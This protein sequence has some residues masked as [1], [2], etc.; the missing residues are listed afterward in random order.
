MKGPLPILGWTLLSLALMLSFFFDFANVSEG[1]AIDLRNRITGVRLLAHGIDPF[2]YK[3]HSGEPEIYCDPYNNPNLTVSKTTATPTLLLLHLPLAWLPYRLGQMLWFLLQWVFL[4]GMAWLW[5][6][7]CATSRQ[8]LLLMLAVTAFTYTAAWRLHAERGQSYVLLLLVFAA[9]LVTTRHPAR[10][11][12]LIAGCLA[13]FLAALR[14]PFL[15][16]VPFLAIH[17]RGQLPG[18]ALGL[19]LGLILPMMGAASCWPD[20]VGAMQTQS[21]NYRTDVN[22]H[23]AQAYPPKIEGIPTEA[24]LASFVPIPFADFSAHHLLSVTG[25]GPWPDLPVLL[26]ILVPFAAWLWWTRGAQVDLL[27]PGLAAWFFLID[28]FLPAFRNSYNDVLILNVIA[29]GL[30]TGTRLPWAIWPCLAALP[31]GWYVSFFSPEQAMAI[32]LPTAMF[33]IGALGFIGMSLRKRS[34]GPANNQAIR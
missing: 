6:R 11:N 15:L 23:Y 18:A 13:G 17:R 9:W 16:L 21:L 14:P 19:L 22:P 26:L 12:G 5:F 3:W 32:N 33:T 28:L 1:G 7:E 8:R 2:H 4:L 31:L 29:L 27:L 20:Y 24:I 34:K 25:L 30:V 10:G